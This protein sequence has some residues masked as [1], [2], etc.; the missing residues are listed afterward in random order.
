MRASTCNAFAVSTGLYQGLLTVKAVVRRKAWNPGTRRN[1]HFLA[2]AAVESSR[3]EGDVELLAARSHLVL[4]IVTACLRAPL[5]EAELSAPASAA[6]A[7]SSS[8]SAVAGADASAAPPPW[9]MQ[10]LCCERYALAA[11]GQVRLS[12]QPASR[13]SAQWARMS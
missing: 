13:L 8:K 1:F 11:A 7:E 10:L 3:L 2:C 5:R 12:W 4:T 9:R 6:E